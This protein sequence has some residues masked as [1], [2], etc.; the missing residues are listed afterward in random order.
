VCGSDHEWTVIRPGG[1][2]DTNAVSDYR[3]STS[4]LPGR[5]TSRADLGNALLRQAVGGRHVRSFID[6]RT[7]EGVPS[8]LDVIRK[9]AFGG[10]K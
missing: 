1:L 2:F 9:E 6:V 3:V 7:T 4:R 10:K 8:F 5:F